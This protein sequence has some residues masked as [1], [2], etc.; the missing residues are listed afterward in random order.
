MRD[1][2]L[3]RGEPE[4]T[5][6]RAAYNR[7]LER[8]NRQQEWWDEPDIIEYMEQDTTSS[9]NRV[10]VLQQRITMLQNV[11]NNYQIEL[12]ILTE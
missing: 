12:T 3:L 6:A 2:K 10:E 8:N 9:E 5:R 11:I 4:M 7:V 1:F